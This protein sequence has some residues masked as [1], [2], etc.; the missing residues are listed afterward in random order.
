M[1]YIKMK[2]I[3]QIV[4]TAIQTVNKY[5]GINEKEFLDKIRS[6]SDLQFSQTEKKN[7]KEL[8]KAQKRCNELD[9]LIK[10]LYEAN[11]GTLGTS[12]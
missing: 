11:E 10:K 12:W 6:M 4:L 7:K 3:E 9:I 1:H 2:D 8:S 5:A